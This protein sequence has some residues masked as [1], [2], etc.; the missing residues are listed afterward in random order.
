MRSQQ[1]LTIVFLLV[2]AASSYSQS[3]SN[4]VI[5]STGN[6]SSSASA[7]LS[8]TSGEAVVATL[9][10]GQ[11]MLTQG[12]Q[13]PFTI[14][15]GVQTAEQLGTVQVYPNPVTDQ[16]NIDLSEEWSGCTIELFDAAGKLVSTSRSNAG[17]CK[18]Q[19]VGL[20][21]GLYE[22]RIIDKSRTNRFTSK[23]NHIQ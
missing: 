9:Q 7:S 17:L 5:A 16:L 18:L 1:L 12:F 3:L 4:Q 10:D 6:Y 21:N 14:T 22:L 13:Q 8:Q 20:A 11:S 15:V 19:F 23:I 2:S